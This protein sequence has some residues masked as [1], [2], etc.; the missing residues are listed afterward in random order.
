MVVG[1][2]GEMVLENDEN[3]S[4]LYD[5]EIETQNGNQNVQT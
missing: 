5:S 1:G 3:L 4:N 2:G